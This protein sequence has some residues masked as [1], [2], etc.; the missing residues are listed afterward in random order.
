METGAKE[1]NVCS[2]HSLGFVW[3]ISRGE[4]SEQLGLLGLPQLGHSGMFLGLG[5]TTLTIPKKSPCKA[6]CTQGKCNIEVC[7][8]QLQPQQQMN[9]PSSKVRPLFG[10]SFMSLT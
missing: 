8:P 10:T 1:P 7:Q 3:T 9:M 6:L 2:H 5:S 4:L